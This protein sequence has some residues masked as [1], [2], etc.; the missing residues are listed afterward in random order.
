MRKERSVATWTVPSATPPR[1]RGALGDQVGIALRLAGD[2]VE[3]LVDG[4]EGGSA[5]I[6]VRLLQLAM[7]ID[8]RRQVLVQEFDG[9][10]ANV[11]G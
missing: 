2:L 6:P 5:H 3:Q 4:D 1:P 7:K 10:S 9:L 11:L 8:R